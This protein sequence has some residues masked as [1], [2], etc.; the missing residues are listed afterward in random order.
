LLEPVTPFIMGIMI[1]IIMIIMIMGI[2]D[3]NMLDIWS[4]C[5]G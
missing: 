3:E 2:M 1:A 4:V 5:W